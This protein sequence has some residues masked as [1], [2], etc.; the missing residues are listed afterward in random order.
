[1]PYLFTC[2]GTTAGTVHAE[3]N[4][5]YLVVFLYFLHLLEDLLGGYTFTVVTYYLSFGIQHGYAV[6]QFGFRTLNLRQLGGTHQFII[7]RAA[8]NTQNLVHLFT[9]NNRIYQ[10]AVSKRLRILQF[11]IFVRKLVEISFAYAARGTD[12]TPVFFPYTVQ[13]KLRLLAVGF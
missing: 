8:H 9:I 4:G 2:I 1:M 10:M 12:C 11:D 6:R 7:L 3:H 13:V 5:F